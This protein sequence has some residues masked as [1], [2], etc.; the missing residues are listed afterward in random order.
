[1]AHLWVCEV[2]TTAFTRRGETELAAAPVR[3]AV[4][5]HHDGRR[6]PAAP[7]FS[8]AVDASAAVALN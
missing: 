1:M 4:C 3:V 6:K 8:V 7:L 2:L 5:E